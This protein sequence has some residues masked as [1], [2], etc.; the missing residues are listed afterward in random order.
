MILL[1][2]LE[3][4]CIQN[5]CHREKDEMTQEYPSRKSCY[6]FGFSHATIVV[7]NKHNNGFCLMVALIVNLQS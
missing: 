6:Q 7:L 2:M 3:L 1:F 5:Q 4:L